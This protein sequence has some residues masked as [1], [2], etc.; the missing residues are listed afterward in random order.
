MFF[1]AP[2]YVISYYPALLIRFTH[3]TDLNSYSPPPNKSNFGSVPRH[4]FTKYL[5]AH[6]RIAPDTSQGKIIISGRLFKT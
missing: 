1:Q 5:M 4:L 6:D 2:L 3:F